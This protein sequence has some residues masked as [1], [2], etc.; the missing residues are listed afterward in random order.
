MR[1]ACH[2]SCD[3][4]I[5]NRITPWERA[6]HLPRSTQAGPQP[7]KHQDATGSIRTIRPLRPPLQAPSSLGCDAGPM[8]VRS[9]IGPAELVGLLKRRS[10]PTPHPYHQLGLYPAP[11]RAPVWVWQ[12]T[13][14]L[15]SSSR[16]SLLHTCARAGPRRRSGHAGSPCPSGKWPTPSSTRARKKPAQPAAALACSIHLSWLYLARGRRAQGRTA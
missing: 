7:S 12:S 14:A 16:R 13:S 8:S 5:E 2:L 11:L 9:R 4:H 3:A 15:L 6:S 10:R 1:Q